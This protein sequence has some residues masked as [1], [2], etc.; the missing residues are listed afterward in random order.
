MVKWIMWG[1]WAGED[2]RP[3]PDTL[4]IDQKQVNTGD[5]RQ[6]DKGTIGVSFSQAD[7]LEMEATWLLWLVLLLY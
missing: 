5:Q 2:E 3:Q 1:F 4:D 6:D 7:C